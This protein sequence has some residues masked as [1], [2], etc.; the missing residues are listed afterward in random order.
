MNHS[1]SLT[2]KLISIEFVSYV[3]FVIGNSDLIYID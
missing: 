1:K 3:Y 2:E